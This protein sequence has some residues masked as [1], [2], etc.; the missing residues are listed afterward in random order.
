MPPSRVGRLSS[1]LARG[2]LG[3]AGPGIVVILALAGCVGRGTQ[4]SSPTRTRS[5]AAATETSPTLEYVR[6]LPNGWRIIDGPKIFV[7]SNLSRYLDGDA[8]WFRTLELVDLLSM[9]CQR[10][11]DVVTVEIFRFPDSTHA[12]GAFSG[13]HSPHDTTVAGLGD[14][15]FRD[16]LSLH[17]WKGD[18]Y[19]RVTG[20]AT[21][22]PAVTELAASLV[23]AIPSNGKL[24]H[25][26][27]LLA[28]TGRVADSESFAPSEGFGQPYFAGCLTARFSSGRFS[29]EGLV[30]RTS[31]RNEATKDLDAY[32]TLYGINGKLLDSIPHLGEE[33]F[34]A[35]DS[36]LGRTVALRRGPWIVAYRGFVELPVLA[37]AAR[38]SDAAIQRRIAESAADASG[39]GR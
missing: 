35:E 13:R 9:E 32:R 8:D 34:A 38:E 12:F 23:T 27:D 24:P 11:T 6:D 3:R 36:L 21:R 18:D 37:A 25:D 15:A 26:F 14:R 16:R 22:T 33:S 31:S 7:A 17:V 2:V 19:V 5:P 29:F 30:L 10:G 4:P 20:R 28:A 39:N 1:N